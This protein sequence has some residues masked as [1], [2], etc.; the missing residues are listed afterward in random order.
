MM[1]KISALAVLSLTILPFAACGVSSDAGPAC[2]PSRCQ[3]DQM[4]VDYVTD[5]SKGTQ[6]V[7]TDCAADDC[8]CAK[9]RC[10]NA[11]T[12]RCEVVAGGVHLSNCWLPI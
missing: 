7:G 5:M 12:A 2:S 1:K 8:E 6:C 9:T 4:C 3:P 10:N 11:T